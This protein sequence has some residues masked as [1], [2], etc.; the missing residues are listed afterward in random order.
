LNNKACGQIGRLRLTRG[1]Q[2]IFL[3]T[4]VSFFT[5]CLKNPVTPPAVQPVVSKP[6]KQTLSFYK[7]GGWIPLGEPDSRFVPGSIFEMKP[8][9]YPRWISSL[10]TCG[11]PDDVSK[12]N[13]SNGGTFS[14][15]GTANYGAS[16]VAKIKGVTL[17]PNFSKATTATLDQTGS[18]PSGLNIIAIAIWM[19][20]NGG[21][22]SS[23]CTGYLSQ[24]DIYVAQES[25]LV[26]SGKYTLKDSTGA[27]LNLLGL[28]NKILSL[29]ANADAT[30]TA[31]S[32]LQL[33][34]P[35]YT[36]LHAAV[37]ANGLLK[38]LGNPSAGAIPVAD[39]QILSKLPE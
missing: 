2:F 31:D 36:A 25:Y 30:I 20:K 24:P 19:S 1:S 32:S 35:V 6:D 7:S 38:T 18:G 3:F 5:A 27:K 34:V 39:Q 26:S 9:Q 16:V 15:T 22:F 21:A 4:A 11:V 10:G 13:T 8:S 17:G 14:Y 12:P 28:N 29:S 33:S 37:E 23:I